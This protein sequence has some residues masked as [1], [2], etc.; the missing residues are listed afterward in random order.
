MPV[1]APVQELLDKSKKTWDD[2]YAKSESFLR[3][4]ADWVVRFHNMYM[5]KNIPRGRVLDYGFGAG[6]NSVFF[7]EQGYDVWGVDVTPKSMEFLQKNLT[8]R[9]LVPVLSQN[10]SII[11][12]ENVALPFADN[13]FDF[14]LSNQVLYYIPSAEQIRAVCRELSRCLRPGGAVFFSMMGP[15]NYYL[16]KFVARVHP[17]G[18]REI[19][20]DDPSHRLCGNREFMYLVEDEQGLRDLFAE[21][22]C[23]STGFFNESMLDMPSN[24]HWIF[25][26]TKCFP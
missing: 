5:K 25:I 26:G 13:F 17:G 2:L 4:P 16:R 22:T 7:L 24:F 14:I 9:H 11:P 18:I 1:S 20:I 3:Y 15:Q 8:W 12:P 23:V 19:Y 6:N 10:F 21:F